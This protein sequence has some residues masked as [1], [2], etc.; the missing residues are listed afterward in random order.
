MNLEAVRGLVRLAR[1]HQYLKNLF[2]LLPVFFGWKLGDAPAMW[3]AVKA[4]VVFCLAA[5]A[6]YVF[7]DLR[8]AAE[9]RQH[10]VKRQRPVA[11]GVVSRGLAWGF[12]AALLGAALLLTP[13]VPGRNF[14]AILLAYLVINIAYSLGIKHMAIVD[15]ISIAVGFVLRVFAGGSASGITPS[16]WI[17]IMTF[18]LALFLGLA[19]RRDDL[20]LAAGGAKSRKSLD[21][22]SLEFVSLCMAVMGAVVI[23]SYILYTLSPDV[24][25]KHGTDQLYLTGLWVVAGILRYIQITFVEKRS[26]SPTQVLLRDAFIQVC[27]GLWVVSC[28]LI[29]YVFK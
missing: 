9:D 26:G 15:L 14:F 1:P 2:V 28:W 3:G 16:H 10:P 13:F 4:F 8:D 25:A 19:K 6:V 5:S 12:A 17:V 20:L 7:N 29:L 22:Y 18:L 11:S 23:V 24:M 27:I 21:G